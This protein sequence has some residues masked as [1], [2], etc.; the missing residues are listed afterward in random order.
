MIPP[1]WFFYA[2]FTGAVMIKTLGACL[3]NGGAVVFIDQKSPLGTGRAR[4]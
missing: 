3:K 1:E 2:N 4:G